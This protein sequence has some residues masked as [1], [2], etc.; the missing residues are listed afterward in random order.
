MPATHLH[1]VSF[2]YTTAIDVLDDVTLSLGPGWH[3]LVGENGSGKTTLLRLIVGV[4]TPTSGRVVLDPADAVVGWC[5]Q[6]VDNLEASV[7]RFAD[8]WEASA[9]SLR[10]RLDLDRAE[11][12]RW[13]TLSPGERRRWQLAAALATR[14]DVLCVDEPTNHLDVEAYDLLVE[15]LGRF[16]GVGVIVSHER[17]LLDRLTTSTIRLDQGVVRLWG[18]CYSVAAQAWERAEA[19]SAAAVAELRRE[20]DRAQQ[21]LQARRRKLT[22]TQR[23]DHSRR[24]RSGVSDPD[25]RSIV[26]KNRQA[27][28][29]SAQSAAAGADAAR[30]ARLEDRLAG[31][32]I[33]RRRGGKIAIDGEAARRPVLLTHR[34]LLVAGGHE[35]SGEMSVDIERTTRLQVTGP[36]GAGK[37]TLLRSLVEDP[38]IPPDRIMWL[39]QELARSERIGLLRRVTDLPREE[40]GEVMAVAARLGLDPGRV[41]DSGEPSPGEARKLWLADGLGRRVW[42]AVLDEPTNHLDLPSIERLEQALADYEG[43]LV[44][45]THDDRFAAPLTTETLE[46][47]TDN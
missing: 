38:L 18:G 14:P 39:P 35:I 43:A 22:E 26:V 46:L 7:R 11:L 31:I 15:E 21:R 42:V 8:S 9:S 17:R 4:F 3:G 6:V 45:V 40:R 37:T 23:R 28:A 1:S 5:P 13:P 30:L 20:R 47:T 32:D 36:N 44:L 19:E 34:G 33:A 12:D 2:S 41:L 29:A 24:R 27:N 10:A 16:G 25:A